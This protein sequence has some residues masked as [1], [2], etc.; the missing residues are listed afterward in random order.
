MRLFVRA[1][2]HLDG[3]NLLPWPFVSQDCVERLAAKK[4]HDEPKNRLLLGLAKL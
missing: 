1:S 4:L 2:A 3:I